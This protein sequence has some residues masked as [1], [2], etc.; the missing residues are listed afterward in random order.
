MGWRSKPKTTRQLSA[1]GWK[2][3]IARRRHYG[4]AWR[5]VE[6]MK[7]VMARLN[8]TRPLKPLSAS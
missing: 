5:E 1:V 7:I 8:R 4:I 2:V 3:A 6:E